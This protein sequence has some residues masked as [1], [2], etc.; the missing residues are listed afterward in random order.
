MEEKKKKTKEKKKLE[1]KYA[2]ECQ[3]EYFDWGE[4]DDI[5]QCANVISIYFFFVFIIIF[6]F[7]GKIKVEKEEYHFDLPVKIFDENR[8]T[9]C[10]PFVI[11][12]FRVASQRSPL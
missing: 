11:Q 8:S 2:I 9:Y 1:E 10:S 6:K 3:C 5:K 7:H 4:H 12:Q